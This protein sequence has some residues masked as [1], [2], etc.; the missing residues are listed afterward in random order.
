M[1]QRLLV[2]AD[3]CAR[4]LRGVGPKRW[5]AEELTG[6]A[7]VR[8]VGA[9]RPGVSTDRGETGCPG[10]SY[11]EVWNIADRAKFG[12]CPECR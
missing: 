5:E 3:F 7:Q 1:Y 6:R 9:V 2:E 10:G 8:E 11:R 12:P 4:N